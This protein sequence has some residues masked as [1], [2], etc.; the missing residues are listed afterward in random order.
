VSEIVIQPSNFFV[1]QKYRLFLIRKTFFQ[2]KYFFLFQLNR[3]F[4]G[5][6]HKR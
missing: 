5:K 1:L 3:I 6:I 2:K 4:A